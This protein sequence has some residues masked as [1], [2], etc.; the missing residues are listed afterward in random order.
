MSR[1]SQERVAEPVVEKPSMEEKAP[2]TSYEKSNDQED[3]SP[4]EVQASV[5]IREGCF[6]ARIS[7][8][9]NLDLDMREVKSDLNE[10]IEELLDGTKSDAQP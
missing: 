3:V 5:K 4:L 2:D 10:D 7:K 9:V 1:Q 8:R 6:T